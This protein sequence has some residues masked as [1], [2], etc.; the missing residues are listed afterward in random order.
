[1]S[2]MEWLVSLYRSD[3]LWCWLVAYIMWLVFVSMMIVCACMWVDRWF[4]LRGV[5]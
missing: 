3:R 4:F 2:F 1:M 5:R